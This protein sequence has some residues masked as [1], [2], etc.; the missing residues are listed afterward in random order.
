MNDV[1][2]NPRQLTVA[3]I[4]GSGRERRIEPLIAALRTL[5]TERVGAGALVFDA[6]GT[7]VH[8]LRID[9][10]N[11][12]RAPVFAALDADGAMPILDARAIAA[13][14]WIVAFGDRPATPIARLIG[15]L[16]DAAAAEQ[17]GDPRRH[18]L[19]RWSDMLGDGQELTQRYSTATIAAARRRVRSA[20]AW[21]VFA[22]GPNVEQRL[23]EPGWVTAID[24][25][26]R[27]L[28][29]EAAALIV[30]TTSRSLL[31][32]R[33]AAS[34]APGLSEDPAAPPPTWLVV[35]GAELLLQGPAGGVV[36]DTIERVAKQGRRPGVGLCL[37]TESLPAIPDGCLSQCQRWIAGRQ[38]HREDVARLL[39][40]LPVA[41]LGRGELRAMGER[42]G[43]L[44]DGEWLV[45][46]A[47]GPAH[48]TE[49]T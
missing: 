11:W 33:V 42:L 21:G 46:G 45:A 31:R 20:A 22:E 15:E 29:R 27:R 47:Q 13:E 43:G 3:A 9:G 28:A 24:L 4:V 10:A 14:D 12:P 36:R 34:C 5:A 37:E 2:L 8:R 39:A 7:L 19:Q 40:R 38:R 48:F 23:V 32:R 49:P 25:S 44:P 16:V 1:L 17:T 35:S 30:A 18:L 41:G 6:V 26:H